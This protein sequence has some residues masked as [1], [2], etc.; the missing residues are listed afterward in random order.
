MEPTVVREVDEIVTTIGP[1]EWQVRRISPFPKRK[2][3]ATGDVHRVRRLSNGWTCC[4]KWFYFRAKRCRHIDSV[5]KLLG[6]EISEES[7]SSGRV[8]ESRHEDE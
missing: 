6:E 7:T 3:P 2:T 8:N 5:R 4:C 1:N